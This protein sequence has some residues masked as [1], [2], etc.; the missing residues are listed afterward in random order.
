MTLT[1]YNNT[2]RD[3]EEMVQICT[4][5]C[6]SYRQV[7]EAFSKQ[8]Y[9]SFHRYR[10]KRRNHREMS[11]DNFTLESK[12]ILESNSNCLAYSFTCHQLAYLK[13]CSSL[14]FHIF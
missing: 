7:L 14:M 13:K 9:I 4:Q 3:E 6:L 1:K 10:T 2:H 11:G 12:K 8:R 5:L